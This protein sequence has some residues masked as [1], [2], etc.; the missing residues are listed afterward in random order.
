MEVLGELLQFIID[1]VKSIVGLVPAGWLEA[2]G[3]IALIFI[4]IKFVT[5]M[6]ARLVI[7]I[8][9]IAFF[10]LLQSGFFDSLL[11]VASTM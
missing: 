7:V 5:K 6:I 2:I 4:V 11:N 9:I 3:A 8:G 10:V 1:L